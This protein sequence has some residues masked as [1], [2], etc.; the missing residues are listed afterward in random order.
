MNRW[1][2]LVFR[3]VMLAAPIWRATA[4]EPAFD[5]GAL[6]E[7]AKL[8]AAGDYHARQGEVPEW[9]RGISYDQLRRIEFNGGLSLWHQERLPF[10]VQYLHPGFLF[11]RT[12]RLHE[13]QGSRAVPIPFRRDYFNYRDV[14]AGPMPE[15]MGFAGIRLMFPWAGRG[16]SLSEIG[17]FAGASYFRFLC[18]RAAYG[19][20]ARGLAIDTAEPTPEEFPRFTEFWLERPAAEANQV[21]VFALL[22]SE[23]AAGAYR[24]AI[25]PGSTTVVEVKAAI[26]FRKR[27][28]VVG[29][30]PLTSMFWRGE[31][32]NSGADDFRP[33]VHDSDGLSMLTGTGE[34]IWRPL[35]NH[36]QLR[37]ATFADENPR[38]FGLLQRDRNFENYQDLEASYHTRPSVWVEPLGQWGK[39]GVRLVEIPTT[40][41]FDDNVVAFW[42]PAKSPSP[43]E[44]FK[45]EY[46]LHWFMERRGPPAGVVR[47]TRSGKSAYYEPGLHRFVVDFDG[48]QL[49]ALGANA[50]L[51]PVVTVGTGARF[52]H[53][54]IQKNRING[55]WRVAFTIKPD[56]PAR[57]VE[58]RCFVRGAAGAMTETWS[59]LWQP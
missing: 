14:A 7:R 42:V 45:F 53:A 59:Y 13:L 20:S 52:N 22:E 33:E 48:P 51:E 43:G 55:T 8:L 31:N 19:L 40:T 27:V 26:F 35:V 39:G 46:Q 36:R 34:W 32:S 50:V 38:G 21:V 47:A 24:F 56:D 1:F 17:S 3:W 37:V 23:S 25:R 16:Q 5:F 28:K 12:I 11:D 30:A 18:A 2:R 54:S 44:A 15:S 58:L 57:P 29:V 4:A 10:E 6:R 41:E 9:L 49:Q